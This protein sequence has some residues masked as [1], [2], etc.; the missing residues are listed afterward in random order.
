[1][2]T[3]LKSVI[4]WFCNSLFGKFRLHQPLKGWKLLTDMQLISYF[5]QSFVKY[6]TRWSTYIVSYWKRVEIWRSGF[7]D[8]KPQG[9]QTFNFNE[10]CV[11]MYKNY[12][13][14][15]CVVY[16]SLSSVVKYTIQCSLFDIFHM[17][18]NGRWGSFYTLQA[19]IDFLCKVKFSNTHMSFNITL[20][21]KNKFKDIYI[22]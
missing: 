22:L 12:K 5:Y 3:I 4:T 17:N 19:A 9:H 1:M 7:R 20:K 21:R 15:I 2:K 14:F 16:K 8:Y 11:R 6:L 18:C 10:V 13:E